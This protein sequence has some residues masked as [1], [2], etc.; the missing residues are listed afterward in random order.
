LALENELSFLIIGRLSGIKVHIKVTRTIGDLKLQGDVIVF[1]WFY[2]EHSIL[3]DLNGC[4]RREGLGGNRNRSDEAV[5]SKGKFVAVANTYLS[6][7]S[8]L[9]TIF[10]CFEKLSLIIVKVLHVFISQVLIILVIKHVL[11]NA[12]EGST[13]RCVVKEDAFQLRVRESLILIVKDM[14]TQSV[15]IIKLDLL[16][17]LEV[18]QSFP[19][20]IL[21]RSLF[22]DVSLL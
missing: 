7:V 1:I 15:Q 22:R 5:Y 18:S 20:L 9:I 16:F 14:G 2:Y 4:F 8:M 17:C 21:F 6:P 19:S 12:R 3:S 13:A 11:L 10:R